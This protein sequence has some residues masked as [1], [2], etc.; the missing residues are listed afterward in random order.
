M[1]KPKVLV[2][3][4]AGFIGSHIVEKLLEKHYSVVVLDNLSSGTMDNLPQSA[5][6][7][8]YCVH[9]E[10]DDLNP[11][12]ELEKPDYLIHLAAQTCVT[13]SI[14]HTD[15]DANVNIM[16]SIRL[17]EY[18]KKYNIKKFITAS[19][20]AVYGNP[21]YLPVDENHP[22]LPISPYGLS[23]LTME[24]YIQLFKIPYIIFRFSNVFGPR[25]KSSKES[26]VIAIFDRLMKTQSPVLIYGDGEQTRDFV[27]VE[28]IATI[29]VQS[30]TSPLRNEILNISTNQG[31][32][33]N[34]LF[35]E[36]KIL[37]HYN[38]S[39]HYLPER[40]GEIRKS[41]LSNKKLIKMMGNVQTF[42]LKEGLVN[43]E[44]FKG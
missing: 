44:K 20:A 17:L 12:F 26:G 41:I 16:G 9:I 10:K 8:F 13:Y 2:T 37:Y 38:Q 3:G 28:D 25:Q 31:I 11:I 34:Q 40:E 42:S 19:T 36:M 22:T 39:P 24:N 1:T 7:K 29:C 21:Q 23:K 32:S 4:G 43:L 18:S 6:L 15:F 14:A 5:D 30:I 33:I 35:D 27:Y